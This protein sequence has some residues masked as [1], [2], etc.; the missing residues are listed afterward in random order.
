VHAI[1]SQN[2][3]AST[4]EYQGPPRLAGRPFCALPKL[5]CHEYNILASADC[6][7]VIAADHS[8][9]IEGANWDEIIG[10]AYRA[11]PFLHH[12]WGEC[13]TKQGSEWDVCDKALVSQGRTSILPDLAACTKL[14]YQP[15]TNARDSL[16][17]HMRATLPAKRHVTLL[18][19]CYEANSSQVFPESIDPLQDTVK[20]GHY[21]MKNQKVY[22]DIIRFRYDQIL[23]SGSGVSWHLFTIRQSYKN[24][25]FYLY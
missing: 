2:P 18:L 14:S 12:V 4:N 10:F 16:T 15:Y 22:S 25:D 24:G 7:T 20:L 23:V 3:T 17:K 6:S 1:P 13:S 21:G 5:C 19:L 8:A 11:T 9:G